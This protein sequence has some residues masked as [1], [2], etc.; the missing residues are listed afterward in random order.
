MLLQKQMCKSDIKKKY[1]L[2]NKQIDVLPFKIK[3]IIKHGKKHV[4]YAYLYDEDEVI[5]LAIKIHGSIENI[6]RK[7]L[8]KKYNLS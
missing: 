2:T 3:D 1:L 5:K 4:G 7:L 8:S 6:Q